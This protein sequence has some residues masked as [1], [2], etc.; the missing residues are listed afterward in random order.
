MRRSRGDQGGVQT[1]PPCCQHIGELFQAS[2]IKWTL[3]LINP[4]VTESRS[5]STRFGDFAKLV[6]SISDLRGFNHILL[7]LTSLK[8]AKKKTFTQ[9][10][11]YSTCLDWFDRQIIQVLFSLTR[12]CSAKKEFPKLH[13]VLRCKALHSVSAILLASFICNLA[14]ANC[15]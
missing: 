12:P 7:Q 8:I 15:I 5:S 13:W 10:G 9:T 6:C 3:A 1:S 2:Q 4:A 11:C 14:T